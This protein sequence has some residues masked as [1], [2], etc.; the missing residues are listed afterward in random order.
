MSGFKAKSPLTA[1]QLESMKRLTLYAAIMLC[2]STTLSNALERAEQPEGDSSIVQPHQPEMDG[3][4]E[5][6]ESGFKAAPGVPHL[7]FQKL[8][9]KTTTSKIKNVTVGA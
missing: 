4:H 6:F 2:Y 3:Q 1:A 9:E 8:C 5:E 7:A